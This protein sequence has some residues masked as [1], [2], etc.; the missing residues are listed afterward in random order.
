MADADDLLKSQS[1]IL[2]LPSPVQRV[3][4]VLYGWFDQ[5][6]CLVGLGKRVY[7]N[8]RK[9][10]CALRPAAGEDRLSHFLRDQCCSRLEVSPYDPR[11]VRTKVDNGFRRNATQERS[12]GM[13]YIICLSRVSQQ[14]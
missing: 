14:L 8:G 6:R 3:K 7:E 5:E 1:D 9:D 2:K 12:H 11:V 10:L 13:R 4:D